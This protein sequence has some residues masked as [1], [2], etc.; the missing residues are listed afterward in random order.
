MIEC[1]KTRV[2]VKTKEGVRTRE[3][4]RAREGIRSKEGG[5][6]HERVSEE[7]GRCWEG[8]ERQEVQEGVK[9]TGEC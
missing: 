8:R 9:D 3:G 6:S 4:V 1:H 5:R 7:T 2:G